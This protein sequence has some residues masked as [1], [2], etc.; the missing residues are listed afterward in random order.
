MQYLLNSIQTNDHTICATKT[1][2]QADAAKKNNFE[3]AA[4]FIIITGPTTNNS[5]NRTND[6]LGS[7]TH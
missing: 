4:D 2:I 6:I 7:G 5:N 1:T 3:L